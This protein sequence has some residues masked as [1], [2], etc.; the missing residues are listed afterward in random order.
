MI[1]GN[2]LE[3]IT[4]IV[5]GTHIFIQMWSDIFVEQKSSNGPVSGTNAI[6]QILFD[7]FVL[8]EG[9]NGPIVDFLIQLMHITSTMMLCE[10]RV[11][12]DN[13]DI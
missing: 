2:I 9:S 5:S 7:I 1:Y 6:I 10:C 4:H 8:S 11:L 12:F 13:C 3:L